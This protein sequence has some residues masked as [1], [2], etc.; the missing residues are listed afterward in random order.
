MQFRFMHTADWQIGR[1]FSGF[2]ADVA[3]SLAEE[4]FLVVDRIAA[5]ARERA[6]THVLV[7]GDVLDKE[8]VSAQ[9]L[10]RLL[11]KLAAHR[12]EHWHLLPGNHDPDRPGGVFERMAGAG[13]PA[14][15]T[16][17]RRA[18]PVEIAPRVQLLP[19]PLKAKATALDP[20]AWMDAATSPPGHLRIGL[21]HGSVAGFC[22]EGETAVPIEAERARTAGLDFLALG[23]WHG[24]REAGPRAHY[25]GTPEPDRFLDNDPGQVLAVGLAGPGAVPQIERIATARFVWLK[26]AIEAGDPLALERIEAAISAAGQPDRVLLR[27]DI[28]GVLGLDARGRLESRLARLQMAIRHL[29]VDLD[30]VRLEAG[31][32]GLGGDWAAGEI[33]EV[34]SRLM[35]R[36]EA[37]GE[38]GRT[39]TDALLRL[40]SLVEE[41][42]GGARP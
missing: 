34:A 16:L 41:R 32:G 2:P 18:E 5:A 40:R 15:V 36:L 6:V 23:D 26:R 13:L 4:R 8:R 29:E 24:C 39:A 27:L 20:T 19:A 37:G 11:A 1:Q 25:S 28:A 10:G 21:A 38:E 7:A 14:N 17:H 3:A 33:A 22:E 35:A 31:S 9:V 30:E 12:G 42:G